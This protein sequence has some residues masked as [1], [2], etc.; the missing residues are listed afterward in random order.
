MRQETHTRRYCAAN[1]LSLRHCYT[2]DDDVPLDCQ[3]VVCVRHAHLI[4]GG[5]SECCC[6]RENELN[7]SLHADDAGGGGTR[8]GRQARGGSSSSAKDFPILIIK[9]TKAKARDDHL[10]RPKPCGRGRPCV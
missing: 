9:W 4:A 6:S 1:E 5:A 10:R 3:W 7:S 8:G 2:R